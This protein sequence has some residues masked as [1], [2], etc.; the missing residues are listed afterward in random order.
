MVCYPA[1]E[2]VPLKTAPDQQEDLE[3]GTAYQETS[4]YAASL[5][6]PE[7]PSLINNHNEPSTD[8]THFGVVRT[9]TDNKNKAMEDIEL[10]APNYEQQQRMGPA[11]SPSR[12]VRCGKETT[13]QE[14]DPASAVSLP[15]PGYFSFVN[16]HNEPSAQTQPKAKKTTTTTKNKTKKTEDVGLGHNKYELESLEMHR[17]RMMIHATIVVVFVLA[18]IALVL[19]YFQFYHPELF[20]ILILTTMIM[21]MVVPGLPL[22]VLFA[23]CHNEPSTQTQPNANGTTKTEDVERGETEDE[24][25]SVKEHRKWMIHAT[26][27]VVVCTLIALVL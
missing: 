20:G 8:N 23:Y 22:R 24:L 4:S 5:P 27:W 19:C 12:C 6:P 21:I 16:S 2:S 26:I 3:A 11:P 7:Y 25:E 14:T 17:R 9:T 10:T 1:T 15:P 13:T 18:L